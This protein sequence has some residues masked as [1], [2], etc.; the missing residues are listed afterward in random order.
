MAKRDGDTP[1]LDCVAH[2]FRGRATKSVWSLWRDHCSLS[3]RAA[4]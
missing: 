1:G 3:G 4:R 2:L